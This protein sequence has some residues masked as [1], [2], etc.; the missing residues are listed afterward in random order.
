MALAV[1]E[2]VG[3][4]LNGIGVGPS[5]VP[6]VDPHAANTV[7]ADSANKSRRTQLATRWRYAEMECP[8]DIRDCC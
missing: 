6:L 1:G 3:G 7:I 5:E 2:G 4:A 8:D